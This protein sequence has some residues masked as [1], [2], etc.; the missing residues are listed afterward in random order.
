M[1][2]QQFV[3]GTPLEPAPHTAYPF[4]SILFGHWFFRAHQWSRPLPGTTDTVLRLHGQSTSRLLWPSQ[5]LS[6]RF[7]LIPRKRS[8]NCPSAPV[9]SM[10][11]RQGHLMREPACRLLESFQRFLPHST[12]D[13]QP[14]C[15]PSGSIQLQSV[16]YCRVVPSCGPPLL[17]ENLH[18]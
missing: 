10:V 17:E 8:M 18:S 16:E 3:H 15:N 4:R 11:M 6:G 9:Q 5:L 7:G 13:S 2:L 14:S 12:L 1:A